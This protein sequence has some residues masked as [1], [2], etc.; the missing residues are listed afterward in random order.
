MYLKKINIA[1][2]LLIATAT[3]SCYPDDEVPVEDL[4]TTSTFYKPADFNPAPETVSILWDVVQ[5]KSEDGDNDIPYDGEVDEEI[6]NTTLDNLVALYGVEN[7]IIISEDANPSPTPSN[8]NVQI[9]TS[10]DSIPNL[11]SVFLASILLR[12]NIVATV[13]PGYPWWG[14]WWCYY[15]WYPPVVDFDQYDVGTVVLD[16]IDLRQIENGDETDEIESSWVAAMRGLLTSSNS[17]NAERVVSGINQAF[18][19]SQYLN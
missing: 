9:I 1:I 15:C 14:G 17:F 4:D 12:T 7:V 5:I 18:N 8:P 2:L 13:Y 11:D 3:Y 10:D 16:L 6:L 19:Q